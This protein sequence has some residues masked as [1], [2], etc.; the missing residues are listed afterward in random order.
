[1]DRFLDYTLDGTPFR[2]RYQYLR[3]KQGLREVLEDIIDCW[4]DGR[5]YVLDPSYWHKLPK[6]PVPVG[7]RR[8]IAS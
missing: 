2:D 3:Y 7:E 5:A 4:T 8:P 1:L 6:R